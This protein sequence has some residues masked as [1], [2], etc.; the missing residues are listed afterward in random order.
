MVG[1][2]ERPE[3]ADRDRLD[4]LLAQAA[5]GGTHLILVERHGHAVA[6]AALVDLL[7]ARA[8]HQV[9]RVAVRLVV[10]D[11]RPAGAAGEAERVLEARRD[12]HADLGPAELG[13]RVRHDGRREHD[14]AGLAEQLA[15]RQAER[16]A[17][18]A[19]RLEDAAA[20]LVVRRQGLAAHEPVGSGHG[21]IGVGATHVD[22]DERREFRRSFG[23]GFHTAH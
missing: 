21:D 8:R 2:T 5:D 6:Q 15:E 19:D 7:D 9:R 1:V 16:L 22:A 10:E 23:G 4:V 20:V 18:D 13:E 12:E 3:E 17:R 14:V 11:A